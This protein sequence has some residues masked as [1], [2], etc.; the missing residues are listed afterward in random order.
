MDARRV[1][2]GR[3]FSPNSSRTRIKSNVTLSHVLEGRVANLP[4]LSPL[5]LDHAAVDALLL[6]QGKGALEAGQKSAAKG[7]Q[8][9]AAS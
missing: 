4:S 8:C 6:G 7:A 3:L 5:P 9:G 2:K 1:R